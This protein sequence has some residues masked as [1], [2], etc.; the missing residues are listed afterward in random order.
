LAGADRSVFNGGRMPGETT[1]AAVAWK[2]LAAAMAEGIAP[3][4]LLPFELPEEAHAGGLEVRVPHEQLI[5]LWEKVMRAVGDPGFPVRAGERSTPRE[6]DAIGFACMTRATLGDALEQ[7]VRFSRIWSNAGEWRVRREAG[8]AALELDLGDPQRLGVR[9]GS[10]STIARLVTAGR[11][12]TDSDLVP[13]VVRFRHA[14]P[15]DASTH[16]RFFRAPIEWRAQR[17]E[18]VL[19]DAMLALP[20]IKADP[21]LAAFFERHATEMLARF[22]DPVTVQHGVRR[23]VADELRRGVPSLEVTAARL[24]MSGR[25]LRRRLA[26]E[27][28]TYQKVIDEVRCELAQRYLRSDELAVG[29]VA[30]LLGFSEPSTFHRAFKRWTGKT[31]LEFRA[32]GGPAA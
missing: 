23:V 2:L 26:D 1:A 31:P 16:Q 8:T 22:G 3:E 27:G 5:A 30:F 11:F 18:L 19:A 13:V 15:H 6:Y 4:R 29:A 17:T 12:L 21:G 14:A 25:T 10:E 20:L 7:L 9:C 32:A 24:A 28:T